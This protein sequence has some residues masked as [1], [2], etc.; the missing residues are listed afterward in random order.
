MN[1]Q[2]MDERENDRKNERAELPLNHEPVPT[3]KEGLVAWCRVV[4]Y[5]SF[6]RNAAWASEF[7]H[8]VAQSV[9]DPGESPKARV[10]NR[11]LDRALLSEWQRRRIQEIHG[12]ALNLLHDHCP[13][14]AERVNDVLLRRGFEE[15]KRRALATIEF[16][17]SS[18]MAVAGGVGGV[19]RPS[20]AI[21]S[22]DRMALAEARGGHPRWDRPEGFP[23]AKF[24]GTFFNDRFDAYRSGDAVLL[25]TS[26]GEIIS[27]WTTQSI[28]AVRRN[29]SVPPLM[30]HEREQMAI[31]AAYDT[32]S[33]TEVQRETLAAY[34]APKSKTRWRI[35]CR[36]ERG[37]PFTY[38][39]FDSEHECRVRFLDVVER[40]SRSGGVR[41]F[42]VEEVVS[43]EASA[44]P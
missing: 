22:A 33:L 28:T 30:G 17:V 24:L 35:L 32:A 42:A 15:W 16:C 25:C 31:L 6:N 8:L 44:S 41:G 18:G 29:L 34:T 2:K 10:W 43:S 4:I 23:D 26:L 37:V 19:G 38:S 39:E 9:E 20:S 36:D 11:A 12:D 7:V 3:T 40:E 13:D 14:L 5:D 27:V 21:Q 1:E